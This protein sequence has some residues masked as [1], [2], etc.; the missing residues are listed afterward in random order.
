M[1]G[2]RLRCATAWLMTLMTDGSGGVG[3][4][5]AAH[6]ECVDALCLL[7]GA[8]GFVGDDSLEG[9]S[10]AQAVVGGVGHAVNCTSG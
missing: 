2:Y 8:A 4:F 6:F 7:R 5:V 9:G 10:G 3:V 1:P